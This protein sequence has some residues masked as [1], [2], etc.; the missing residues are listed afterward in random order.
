MI[1]SHICERTGIDHGSEIA[2][3]DFIATLSPNMAQD[4]FGR[5]LRRE[6]ER[7]TIA[8]EA[9]AANTKIG[10]GLL[11][12]LERDDFSR[13][14]SGVFRRAFMRSYAKAIGLDPDEVVREFLERFPDPFG[15]IDAGLATASVGGKH[16]A[17]AAAKTSLRLTLA[18]PPPRFW[19]GCLLASL[20]ARLVAAA[21][22]AAV[23]GVLAL[24]MFLFLDDFRAPLIVAILGYYVGG[25]LILGN[26]PGV[27]ICAPRLTSDGLPAEESTGDAL[28]RP[29][30]VRPA[31]TVV[32]STVEG[33]QAQVDPEQ[34]RRVAGVL[35]SA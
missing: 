13:W 15:G 5:R 6:R 4:S 19:G 12:G 29:S 2:R 22:D 17:T 35:K 16:G 18:E 27:S 24:A 23:I 3:R 21:L 20:R 33:R 25:I 10:L 11:Q 28:P 34:R 8:L 14:P 1:A 32:P 30:T 31:L 9:I 7:R 26:T